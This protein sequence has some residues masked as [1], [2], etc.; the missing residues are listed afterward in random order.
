MTYIL[1][2]SLLIA[3]AGCLVTIGAYVAYK[4]LK[5]AA[6]VSTAVG[7]I[8]ALVAA[9]ISIDYGRVLGYVDS[10]KYEIVTNSNYSLKELKTFKKVGSTYLKEVE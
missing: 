5:L 4:E 9:C 1:G 7:W 2:I 10:G 3:L 6:I 8:F